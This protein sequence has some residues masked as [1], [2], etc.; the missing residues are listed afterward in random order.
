M[1]SNTPVVENFS[2]YGQIQIYQINPKADH[3]LIKYG[4]N[5]KEIYTISTTW[6]AVSCQKVEYTEYYAML[7]GIIDLGWRVF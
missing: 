3:Q 6:F 7:T 1:A 5:S 2:Y 4:A